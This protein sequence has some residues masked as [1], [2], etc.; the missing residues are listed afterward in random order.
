MKTYGC[1]AE[2]NR[3]TFTYTQV[4][5]KL[6]PKRKK[7]RQSV[8]DSRC[9]H[10]LL[11]QS[12]S[13]H[14]FLNKRDHLAINKVAHSLTKGVV[15][16]GVVRALEVGIVPTSDAGIEQHQHSIE[17][18]KNKATTR[19]DDDSNSNEWTAELETID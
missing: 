1:W 15:V 11:A 12:I 18:K 5:S 2:P 4:C 14:P 7:I 16:R 6:R 8:Y 9:I 3:N 10:A 19:D 13:T 17:K